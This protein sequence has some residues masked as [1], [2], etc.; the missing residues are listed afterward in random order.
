MA[1]SN[2]GEKFT[3]KEE[4]VYLRALTTMSII[5]LAST[6][7]WPL[8]TSVIGA[9]RL[10]Q[11]GGMGGPLVTTALVTLVYV[12]VKMAVLYSRGEGGEE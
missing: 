1:K 9:Y 6:L 3:R 5:M 11:A 4:L 10:N 8:V 2:R 7:L 12:A